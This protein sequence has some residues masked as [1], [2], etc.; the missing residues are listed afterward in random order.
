MG[1]LTDTASFVLD[2]NVVTFVMDAIKEF[3][4]ILATPPLGTFLTIGILGTVVGLV[5]LVVRL[6]KH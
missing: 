6:V 4:G 1:F 3:I 2:E 5:A